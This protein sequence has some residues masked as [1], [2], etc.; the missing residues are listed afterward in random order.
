MG[1]HGPEANDR[2]GWRGTAGPVRPEKPCRCRD[3][4]VK[5]WFPPLVDG[6]KG[7]LR[8]GRGRCSVQHS[9]KLQADYTMVND[10]LNQDQDDDI[11]RLQ[12]QFTY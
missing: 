4:P 10:D 11:F 5:G 1:Q 9:L 3:T 7:R 6:W 2:C 8:M 12:A